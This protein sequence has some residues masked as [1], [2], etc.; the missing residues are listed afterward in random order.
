MT[1]LQASALRWTVAVALAVALAV[2]TGA[3]RAP[4]CPD[5]GGYVSVCRE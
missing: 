1:D 2:S 4:V 5:S 3:Y